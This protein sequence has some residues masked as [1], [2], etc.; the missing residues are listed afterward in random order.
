KDQ[1]GTE[2][3]QARERRRTLAMYGLTEEQWDRLVAFQGNRCAI[4]ETA[5]PGGRGESWH[6]DH[7]PETRKVRGLL[8][9]QCNVSIG[10]LRHDPKIIMAAAEYLASP[11]A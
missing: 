10:N 6:I 2:K 1:R 9:H 3:L 8:C 7:D 5:T 4:R 11:P